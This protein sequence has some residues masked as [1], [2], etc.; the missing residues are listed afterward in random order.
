[1]PSSTPT[2]AELP[3]A[4]LLRVAEEGARARRGMIPLRALS[5]GAVCFVALSHAALHPARYMWVAPL[6]A[7]AGWSLDVSLGRRAA[8]F[9]RL[10]AVLRSG[11]APQP[12]VLTLD[13][14]PFEA[15][16]SLRAQWLESSRA[17][18][19]GALITL[20]A[21]VAVDAQRFPAA[22]SL[23]EVLW[24]LVVAVAALGL[25]G[26]IAWSWWLDRFRVSPA[27]APRLEARPSPAAS[28]VTV[29]RVALPP[30][31]P[32]PFPP[33]AA[34]EAPV[35]VGMVPP[36]SIAPAPGPFPVRAEP[37]DI[38]RDDPRPSDPPPAVEAEPAPRTS[39]PTST[40]GTPPQAD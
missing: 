30:G 10:A 39:I 4:H 15:D 28:A 7:F 19:Y 3:A 13:P 27:P 5:T 37:I 26:L 35:S 9:E 11:S 6:L 34:P 40:F 18:Y 17:L 31:A 32:G 22:E 23:Q 36:V 21:G 8:A 38:V 29:S 20:S 2:P 25:L 24:Y 33:R 12:P 16:V 1:M 14:A